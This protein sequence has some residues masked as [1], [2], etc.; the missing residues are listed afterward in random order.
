MGIRL[1]RLRYMN[2]HVDALVDSGGIDPLAFID[3]FLCGM[4]V[5]CPTDHV[6]R[7]Y[8]MQHV[9]NVPAPHDSVLFDVLHDILLCVLQYIGPIRYCGYRV[10]RVFGGGTMILIADAWASG[11]RDIEQ[12]GLG[13]PDHFAIGSAR[14]IAEAI[15]TSNLCQEVITAPHRYEFRDI[16]L[17]DYDNPPCTP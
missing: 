9:A 13:G 3:G 15:M 8:A 14:Q 17:T 12:I 5:H 4:T 11:I 7:Q 2:I 16:S 10:V 1:E 6:V